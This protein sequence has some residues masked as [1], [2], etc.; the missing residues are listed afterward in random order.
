[1]MEFSLTINDQNS[2]P[3]QPTCKEVMRLRN[4]HQLHAKEGEV[5]Y[6]LFKLAF[7]KC[8]LRSQGWWRW[9]SVQNAPCASTMTFPVTTG[10]TSDQ[11]SRLMPSGLSWFPLLKLHSFN[12]M[13]T[14]VRGASDF[15]SEI[16]WRLRDKGRNRHCSRSIVH[17]A[18]LIRLRCGVHK[19]GRKDW[20]N[21]EFTFAGRA[22]HRWR[23]YL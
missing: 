10:Y 15:D 5:W 3:F 12:Q 14:T 13:I 9:L 2:L 6:L 11:T 23:N 8:T 20:Y 21:L 19:W 1:M 4:L 16:P 17:P 22:T 7:S 18:A